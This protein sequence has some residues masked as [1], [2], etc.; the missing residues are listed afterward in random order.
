MRAA[1]DIYG[2]DHVIVVMSGDHVQRG[3]P[4]VMDK[5]AR[6]K[7]AL[8]AGA[9]LVLELPAAFATGSAQ[10]FAR[11][12]VSALI[13]CACVDAI[14]FGSECGDIA[15]INAM[16]SGDYVSEA[17]APTGSGTGSA[18]SGRFTPPAC[19]LSPNDLLATE[20][21]KALEYFRSDIT[22][23]TIKR[24]GTSHNDNKPGDSYASASALR[25]MLTN[26]VSEN[27][28][29]FMPE[30][31]CDILSGYISDKRLVTADM[32]SDVLFCKLLQNRALG[33]AEYYDVFDD[34]SDK[35][36]SKL[37]EYSSFTAFINILKSKDISYSHLSRALLHILL[38]IKKSDI[39]ILTQDYSYCPWLRILGLKKDSA[40]LSMIKRS[41][42]RPLLSKLADSENLLDIALLPILSNDI[43]ASEMYGYY[44]NKK[45]GFISEYR[46]GIA[47]M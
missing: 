37:E 15:G 5:Y 35:I 3:E 7:A 12:A 41:A 47:L 11:G 14:L 18:H 29:A 1:R 9:D 19:R 46:R 4:A 38:G 23:L 39:G 43:S 27:L 42:K 21:L 44:S 2:A 40:V 30:Y 22:P 8:Y 17:G 45:S 28:S 32:Y 20:Y 13:N 34:L 10:Y 31:A 36:I 26:S 16:A 24:T 6:A 33:Y 25:H